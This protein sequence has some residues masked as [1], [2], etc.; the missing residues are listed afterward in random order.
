MRPHNTI[1]GISH[2]ILLYWLCTKLCRLHIYVSG[3]GGI[4]QYIVILY[5]SDILHIIYFI[6]SKTHCRALC[7]PKL[8]PGMLITLCAAPALRGLPEN[9]ILVSNLMPWARVRTHE[10][11]PHKGGGDSAQ[12]VMCASFL[13]A[14]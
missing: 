3:P 8:Y 4:E 11:L 12:T 14:I 13:H 9:K 1:C 5:S 7:A 6:Y 2:H 10:T